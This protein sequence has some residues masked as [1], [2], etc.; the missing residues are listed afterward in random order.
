M[1]AASDLDLIL[2]YEHP[3]KASETDGDRPIAPSQYYARLTQRFVAALSAPTAEGVL[4][5]V[6][7]RL[8]PSGRA[9]PLATRL[10][11]FESY[12]AGEAE[13]WEHMAL[14]R[15]RVVVGPKAFRGRVWRAILKVLSIKRDLKKLAKDVTTMRA[16]LDKEKGGGGPWNLKHAPGGLVDI[17]FIAQT[18]QL[19]YAH[20]QPKTLYTVTTPALERAKEAGL[21][22]EEDWE[23]LASA[24][25]LQLD[26]TQAL[27]LALDKPFEA[28]EAPEGLKLLLAKVG[29]APDFKS[30]TADLAERQ[31]TVRAVFTRIMKGL[32]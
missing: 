7:F 16:L 20:K 6:D 28:D 13:T 8:R 18:L 5:E 30:L 14:C 1:T 10:K 29:E 26:L 3:E 25:R 31:K 22:A 9:G 23:T 21:L 24:A 17:E 11:A 27:R 15:A 4:Y 19:A 32:G 2:L 12:Q